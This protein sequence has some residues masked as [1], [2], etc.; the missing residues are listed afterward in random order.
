MSEEE[1]EEKE[2]AQD[3]AGEMLASWKKDTNPWQ[4]IYYA[5]HLG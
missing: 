5:E 2:E 3:E 1:E 4:Y